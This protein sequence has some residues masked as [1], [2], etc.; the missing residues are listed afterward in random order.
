MEK[1]GFVYIWLDR[2]HKRY[3]IGSHW[4]T[5]DDGYV[6]SSSWMKKALKNRPTDFKRKIIARIYSSKQDLL[7]EENR[8]LAMIKPSEIKERYYN[9]RIHAFGHW[10]ADQDLSLSVK[11]KISNNVKIGMQRPE[12]R[13]NYLKSLET[14]NQIQTEETKRKR[15]ESM[16][17]TMADK[18]PESNR[19]KK[20]SDEERYEY[21]SDKAKN[22]WANM[23][24]DKKQQICDKISQ[25][26]IGIG[27]GSRWW[28]DGIINK[29]TVECPGSEWKL[30]KLDKYK[31][32]GSEM[33][34][35]ISGRG[36]KKTAENRKQSSYYQSEE[37][38]NVVKRGWEK[39]R[40]NKLEK[41]T[42][43][44]V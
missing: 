31:K 21:Y 43:G 34:K 28:N 11:E 7:D 23:D 13:A 22:N 25:S 10:S 38:K 1:Y 37:W 12:V 15:S 19:W 24:L 33:P 16:K 35:E 40:A 8:W 27:K 18:F 5:E 39:R 32:T 30:G 42:G 26:H 29:R 3:Y 41:T 14:R 6:C 9:L 20:L 44:I 4:G 17:K 36:G 2:K